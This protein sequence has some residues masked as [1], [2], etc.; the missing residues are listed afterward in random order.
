MTPSTPLP[1]PTLVLSRCDVAAL[2]TP[3]DYQVA[4]EWGFRAAKQGQTSSPMPMHL[5]VD[6]GA[7]H[8]KGATLHGNA[9]HYAALKL[10][11]NFPGNPARGLPTIQGVIV[12]CAADNG[13]V[14]AIMDSIEI[15]LRRTAAASALAARHLALP[16]ATTLAV[17]GCGGQAAAQAE[18]LAGVLRLQRGFVFDTEATRSTRLAKALNQRLRLPFAAAPTLQDA[19]KAAQVIV[20]CTTARE[21]F[22]T[23]DD[24]MPGAFVAAVGADSPHKNEIAPSLMARAIVV[25]DVLE[26]CLLMGDLHHAVAAGA[27]APGDVQADLGDIVTGERS[28]RRNDD[29]IIVFDSTGTALQDVACAAEVYERARH[30]GRGLPFSLAAA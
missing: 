11:G 1:A 20:T 19:T 22:L 6:Q 21:P 4:V 2:M 29:D 17:I 10:N 25:V 12:L 13:T 26:Q 9:R 24:V 16:H 28:V 3:P 14:L 5:P 8:A 18:A 23:A 30:A 27:L 15:T 7:F